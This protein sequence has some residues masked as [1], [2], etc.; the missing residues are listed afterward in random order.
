MTYVVLLSLTIASWVL[1]VPIILLHS[2]VTNDSVSRLSHVRPGR[3]CSRS[4]PW[5][6]YVSTR[7]T[8]YDVLWCFAS[9]AWY[10]VDSVEVYAN[11]LKML[12][13]EYTLTISSSRLRLSRSTFFSFF[14]FFLPPLAS[15]SSSFWGTV[16]N[17]ASCNIIIIIFIIINSSS[18][19]ASQWSDQKCELTGG[20]WVHLL[21]ELFP[22]LPS[23]SFLSFSSPIFPSPFPSHTS[24]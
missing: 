2:S 16:V 7:S 22:S 4:R 8:M 14:V 18:A 21:S 23:F 6:K 9:L 11:I 20:G 15:T 17:F 1:E 5:Y 12:V 24:R 10:T 13:T 19:S 3:T